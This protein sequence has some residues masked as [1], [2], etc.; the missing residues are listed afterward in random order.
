MAEPCAPPSAARM[1]PGAGAGAGHLRDGTGGDGGDVASSVGGDNNPP[2]PAGQGGPDARPTGDPAT[3]VAGV[4]VYPTTT[5]REPAG[6][7]SGAEVPPASA[8]LP[9]VPRVLIEPEA[10]S[11]MA[12]DSGSYSSRVSA[13]LLPPRPRVAVPAR[14]PV[15]LPPVAP[16]LPGPARVA[17]MGRGPTTTLG[18]STMSVSDLAARVRGLTVK[19][20]MD[21]AGRML[22]DFHPPGRRGGTSR[23]VT[24]DPCLEQE[25]ARLIAQPDAV[26]V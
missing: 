9:T 17:P 19:E 16:V 5:R 24:M 13:L 21:S 6:G 14:V 3:P 26:R 4:T 15:G 8:V 20:P 12:V 2:L 22:V 1:G 7:S 23:P 11:P 25:L 18:A 10:P